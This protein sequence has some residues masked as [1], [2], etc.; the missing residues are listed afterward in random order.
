MCLLFLFCW[1]LSVART[2][3][4]DQLRGCCCSAV[5]SEFD[6]LLQIRF[7]RIQFKANVSVMVNRLHKR[8]LRRRLC[9]R[10]T[11]AMTKETVRLTRITV[12]QQL[13]SVSNRVHFFTLVVRISGSQD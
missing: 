7:M 2:D 4:V 5:Y 10:M 13:Q 8:D 11:R 1:R 3:Q 9:R 6:S 12:D